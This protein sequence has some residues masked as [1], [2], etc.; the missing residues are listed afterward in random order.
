MAQSRKL[1]AKHME[2]WTTDDYSYDDFW[3]DGEL[4][5]QHDKP[6]LKVGSPGLFEKPQSGVRKMPRFLDH[7]DPMDYT[8]DDYGRCDSGAYSV[9]G[10]CPGLGDDDDSAYHTND[11]PPEPKKADDG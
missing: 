6:V 9:N 5:R 8:S 2:D 1:G 7:T 11:A 10:N 4:A 3:S